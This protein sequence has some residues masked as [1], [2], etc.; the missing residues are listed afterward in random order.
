MRGIVLLDDMRDHS[1]GHMRAWIEREKR[2]AAKLEIERRRW[3]TMAAMIPAQP[4]GV[5]LSVK[6]LISELAA[7]ET[8]MATNL[9]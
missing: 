5:P 8:P 4:D 1:G 3:A 7:K 2:W 6:A 9:P